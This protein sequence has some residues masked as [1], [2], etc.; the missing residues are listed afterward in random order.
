[1]VG[2][3][4]A[5]GGRRVP[6]KLKEG[7]EFG[8]LITVAAV[9]ALNGMSPLPAPLLAA[10][11]RADFLIGQAIALRADEIALERR[12]HQLEALAR[13]VRI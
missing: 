1:M 13:A 4:G 12:K 2:H 9:A 7:G 8:D 5:A 6:G 11:T 3:R 10:D